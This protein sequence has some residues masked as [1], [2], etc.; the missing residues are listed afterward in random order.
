[1]STW[2]KTHRKKSAKLWPCASFASIAVRYQSVS[3]IGV[4]APSHFHS[5]T[6]RQ[7]HRWCRILFGKWR[8]CKLHWGLFETHDRLWQKKSR[9]WPT[10]TITVPGCTRPWFQLKFPFTKIV[11]LWPWICACQKCNQSARTRIRRGESQPSALRASGC[12][13]PVLILVLAYDSI[14]KYRNQLL[15]IQFKYRNQL[16]I[17]QCK[18]RNQ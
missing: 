16:L 15:I 14:R 13:S 9:P 3:M 7:H 10:S 18:Y 12:D 5:Q 2:K 11:A 1:M 17:I 8:P 6:R 4:R